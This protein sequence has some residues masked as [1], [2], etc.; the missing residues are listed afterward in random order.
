VVGTGFIWL[1]IGTSKILLTT[2]INLRA[3]YNFGQFLSSFTA[4]SFSRR[5]Q[6]HGV[7]SKIDRC[8]M[9]ICGSLMYICEFCILFLQKSYYIRFFTGNYLF[10]I[11]SFHGLIYVISNHLE[12][13]LEQCC[14]DSLAGVCTDKQDLSH[15]TAK[16]HKHNM[17]QW[18]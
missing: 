6:L 18:F 17:F 4:G 12:L 8:W 9:L 3:P 7:Y 11:Y 1:R 15:H 2:I 16:W 14:Y 13:I 10:P 5:T